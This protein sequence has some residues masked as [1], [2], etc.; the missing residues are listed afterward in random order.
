M[1]EKEYASALNG[2]GFKEVYVKQL[3][4]PGE[5]NPAV[6]SAFVTAIKP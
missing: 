4:K 1:T 2:A 5:L 6:F 3:R